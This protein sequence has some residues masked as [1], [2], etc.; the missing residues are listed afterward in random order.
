MVNDK[1]I[2]PT[3]TKSSLRLL[4]IYVRSCPKSKETLTARCAKIFR[5]DRKDLISSSFLIASFAKNPCVLCGKRL[6]R[7]PQS[8]WQL[9]IN[10]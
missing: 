7:Q 1:M 10:H 5:K 4:P 9:T 8:N 3:N 2:K 6:F